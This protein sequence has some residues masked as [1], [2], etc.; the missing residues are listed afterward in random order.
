VKQLATPI[1]IVL[2][3][4]VLPFIATIALAQERIG[5]SHKEY[6]IGADDLLQISVF[7]LPDLNTTARVSGEG[8]ISLPLLGKLKAAGLTVSQLEEKIKSLLSR[9][10]VNNPQV[11]ILVREYHSARISVI[12]AVK[13][14]GVY[15]LIGRRTLLELIAAAGGLTEE[16]GKTLILIR[17]AE[18]GGFKVKVNLKKLINEGDT[19]LNYVLSPGDVVSIPREEMIN[20]YVSGEVNSPGEVTFRLSDEPTVLQAIA[21]AGGLTDKAA[22]TR[23]KIIRTNEEGKK[24]TIKV[25]LKDIMSGKKEDIPLFPNDVIMVAESYF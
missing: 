25:N 11:T 21:K 17:T 3:A 15:E 2:L 6:L 19:S 18:G 1:L 8:Y 13:N 16:A 5:A 23:V 7:Q 20:I 24:I 9:G 22:K 14:P 12:G 4:F 10:Y